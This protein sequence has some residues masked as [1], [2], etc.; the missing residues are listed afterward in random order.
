MK[1]LRITVEGKTYE[2]IVERFD[3][4]DDAGSPLATAV[5]KP[6]GSAAATPIVRPTAAP[7]A[8]TAAG[9]VISPLAGIVKAVN[10]QIGAV[11]KAGDTL[12]TLEA[13]KM[14]TAI[15]A[16]TD[17]TVTAIHVSPGDAVDE[18]QPLYTLA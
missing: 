4:P 7:K 13:M 5:T 12:M 6:V 3:A 17:G 14:Y 15:S 16:P 11:V 8:A 10:T 18:G 2:V 9:D 1:H